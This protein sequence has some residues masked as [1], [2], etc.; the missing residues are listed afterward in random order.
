MSGAAET[1]D[2]PPPIPM[3]PDVREYVV[4]KLAEILVLDYYHSLA[5]VDGEHTRNE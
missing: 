4:N 2:D 5:P 3:P 1:P